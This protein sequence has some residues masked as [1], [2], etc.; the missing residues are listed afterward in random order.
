MLDFRPLFTPPFWFDLRPIPPSN[1]VFL[2][3]ASFFIA[4]IVTAMG[5]RMWR[6]RMREKCMRV[7]LRRIASMLV[8]IGL[9]GLLFV[10]FH[11]EQVSLFSA[12]FWF[13][14]LA[15][16]AML[17]IVSLVRFAREDIPRIRKQQVAAKLQAKYMKP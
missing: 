14:L 6:Q 2:A 3:L 17:W 5:V 12:R 11:Y 7:L 9:I 4:L 15:L 1:T 13:L 8:T 16:W 10:F